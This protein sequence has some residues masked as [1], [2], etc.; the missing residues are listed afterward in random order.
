MIGSPRRSPSHLRRI[1]AQ[2]CLD[3]LAS[4]IEFVTRGYE[5]Q[6]SDLAAMRGKLNEK[7][8]AGDPNAKKQLSRVRDRQKS[9]ESRK[10]EALASLRREPDLIARRG[11][12]VPRP[13]PGASQ[14]RPRGP[15][16]VRCRGRGDRHE[17]R[18]R[19]TRKPLGPL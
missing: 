11:Y 5:Y 2:R 17:G 10:R 13:R 8:R 19:H 12:P 15:E 18:D 9:L 16:A 7:V 6:E 14:R 1:D 4:R 3:T